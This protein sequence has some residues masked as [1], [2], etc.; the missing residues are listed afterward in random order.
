M[1]QAFRPRVAKRLCD[2]LEFHPTPKHG[3]WLNMA[4]TE[5]SVLG[6]DCL[7]RRM[8]SAEFVASEV[9]AWE[10]DRNQREA[11]ARWRF[12]VGEASIKLE[13]VY[14]VMDALDEGEDED[15][16]KKGETHE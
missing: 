2:R 14:P 11:K 9:Q 16:E 15:D 1:Y 6:G 3:S 13:K 12:T 8:D 7:D 10:A 4:E 5:L